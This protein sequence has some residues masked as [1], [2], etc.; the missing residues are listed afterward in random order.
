MKRK[1]LFLISFLSFALVFILQFIF[2]LTAQNSDPIPSWQKGAT[3]TALIEFV[4]QVT[5]SGSLDF[6]PQSDRIAT[7]D[8]DGT[9]WP[10][11]PVIQVMF[12][13]DRLK[14]MIKDE[15][16]LGEK[17]P[18]QAALKGD[19]NYLKEAGEAAIMSILAATHSGMTEKQFEVEVREFFAKETHPILKKK[20]TNLAYQPMVE[21][22]EYLRKNDFQTWICS[23]GGIDFIRVISPSMYGIPVEQVIGSRLKKEFIE[24]D[25]KSV[26]W[27]KAELDSF[28]D[29]QMKPVNIDLQIGKRPIFAAGNVRSGGDIAML[30]YTKDNSLPSFQLLINHDDAEREFAYA[31][32][33]NLS[34]KTANKSGWQIVSMKNDWQTIFK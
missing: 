19:M 30:T 11:Q 26:I 6:I 24:K 5:T 34:L 8:N 17:Q 27:R 20:Y 9:L 16:S 32:K 31:E 14:E 22:M 21:L 3:K 10:E 29:Q 33:D 2:P 12:V 25:G 15:P 7:F 23:G 1:V 13:L 28:N 18:F 4:N